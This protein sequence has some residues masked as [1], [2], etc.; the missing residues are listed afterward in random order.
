MPFGV[1]PRHSALQISSLLNAV[2]TSLRPQQSRLSA[3]GSSCVTPPK[4]SSTGKGTQGVGIVSCFCARE[5]AQ[6]FGPRSMGGHY[7][8][9]GGGGCLPTIFP[10]SVLVLREAPAA[11]GRAS[12]GIRSRTTLTTAQRS[13]EMVNM[14]LFYFPLQ[15]SR[16][17]SPLEGCGWISFICF[18]CQSHQFL[19][20]A[21]KCGVVN[22]HCS[23]QGKPSHGTLK[24]R[25]HRLVYLR[26][27]EKTPGVSGGV[28]KLGLE[29]R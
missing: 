22:P 28:K 3:F 7:S 2:W 15:I 23:T 16:F 14:L 11:A 29:W 20:L 4:Q 12:R 26:G 21:S 27:W 5:G 9:F 18:F 10:S 25:S 6:I 13:L 1:C 8:V 19:F 24:Y 17:N